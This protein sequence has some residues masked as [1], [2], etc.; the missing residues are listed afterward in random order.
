MLLFC[1]FFCLI[2]QLTTSFLSHATA[3]LQSLVGKDTTLPVTRLAAAVAGDSAAGRAPRGFSSL[4]ALDPQRPPGA[5]QV[6]PG[7]SGSPLD[8]LPQVDRREMIV[9]MVGGASFVEA[10]NLQE[11]A[12]R[13]DPP[14]SVLYGGTSLMTGD[15]FVRELSALGRE[16]E[17]RRR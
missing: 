9:F 8:A 6:P 12:R 4:V 2:A 17:E 10:A 11:W 7:P 3:Q 16:E 1:P 14:C 15:D 13:A 5:E